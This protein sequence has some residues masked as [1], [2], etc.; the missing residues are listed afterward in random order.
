MPDR[1]A[2]VSQLAKLNEAIAAGFAAL[3]K[4]DRNM[5][6]QGEADLKT[7]VAALQTFAATVATELT[8]L[9]AASTAA[10]GDP[11]ADIETLAQQVNA[12]IATITAA[13]PAASAPAPAA[14]P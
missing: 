8:T 11:D 5:A 7:A 12:S 6:N 1:D 10:T 13:M 3:K 14:G 2:L 9:Q 4:G